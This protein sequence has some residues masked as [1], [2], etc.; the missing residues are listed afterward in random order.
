[1][2]MT[3][4]T[5]DYSQKLLAERGF[6]YADGFFSTMGVC[7]GQILWAS[8]HRQRLLSHAMALSLTLDVP[9]LMQQLIERA[10]G[11][12]DG[13]IKVVVSRVSQ[14][15]RGYGWINGDSV[16]DITET[17]TAIFTQTN[18]LQQN[19]INQLLVDKLMAGQSLSFDDLPKQPIGDAMCIHQQIACLPK[20]LVGLKSLNRLDSVL[21]TGELERHRQKQSTL[22]EGLVQ[23]V[24][25]NWVEGVMSNVFYQLAEPISQIDKQQSDNQP[26]HKINANLNSKNNVRTNIKLNHAH[27]HTPPII[28]SGVSGVMRQVVMDTLQSQGKKV[29]E[30]RLTNADLANLSALFFCNAVRGII[31]IARLYIDGR[32]Y[33]LRVNY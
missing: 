28:Q 27:W 9:M 15:V 21:V 11:L 26:Q 6:A 4:R 1:M 5:Q 16:V 25:G 29:N 19:F 13:I 33:E 3:I 10:L 17:K 2:T 22:V 14:P 30:R 32:W 7:Q 8:H 31:P 18:N 23:D 12:G 20:P 24:M